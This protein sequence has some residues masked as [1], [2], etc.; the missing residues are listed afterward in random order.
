VLEVSGF[1]I[2]C[3]FAVLYSNNALLLST[4]LVAHSEALFVLLCTSAIYVFVL[5]ITRKHLRDAI[6]FCVFAG[7]ATSTKL[8]GVML[9][10]LWYMATIFLV[11]YSKR[12]RLRMFWTGVVGAFISFVLF[13]F[14]NP[15]TYPQP[16]ERTQYLFTWRGNVA[17]GQAVE[18]TQ[19]YMHTY[20]ERVSRVLGHFIWDDKQSLFMGLQLLGDT[21]A[22]KYIA[23]FLSLCALVGLFFFAK[24]IYQRNSKAT[25]IVGIWMTMIAMMGLYL[26]IDWVRYYV[27]LTVFFVWFAAVGIYEMAKILLFHCNRLHKH[28]R[29]IT[30]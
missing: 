22:Q 28:H 1:I 23:M 3:L 27:Q 9:M 8:N 29:V 25:A 4:G 30:P 14:L 2:A 15:F 13:I 24:K 19:L 5:Y 18:A 17:Q 6:L 12:M 10:T 16:F 21:M 11:I 7:L 20:T 26:V